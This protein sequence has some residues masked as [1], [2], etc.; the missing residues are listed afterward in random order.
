MV[1]ISE[2]LLYNSCE[3]IS[4]LPL[5]L[6][7][8]VNTSAATKFS[9]HV[10]HFIMLCLCSQYFGDMICYVYLIHEISGCQ[11]IEAAL[12]RSQSRGTRLDWITGLRIVFQNCCH[13]NGLKSAKT[14]NLELHRYC[15]KCWWGAVPYSSKGSSARCRRGPLVKQGIEK[16]APPFPL[17]P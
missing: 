3:E 11:V 9:P 17:I 8:S 10:C 7:L 15:T 14:S 5:I 1:S 2:R 4:I 12:D 16:R 13:Q 6:I